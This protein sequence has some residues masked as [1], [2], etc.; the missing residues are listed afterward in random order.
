MQMA[1]QW[2]W[3]GPRSSLVFNILHRFNAPAHTLS[4][5]QSLLFYLH[6]V[7]ETKQIIPVDNNRAGNPP[8]PHPSSSTTQ[9]NNSSSSNKRSTKQVL[10]SNQQGLMSITRDSMTEDKRTEKLHDETMATVPP[11]REW[12]ISNF[13]TEHGKLQDIRYKHYQCHLS[14]LI[15]RPYGKTFD[16]NNVPL[17]FIF[18][19][20]LPESQHTFSKSNLFETCLTFGVV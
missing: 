18:L 8:R 15:S 17:F 4:P 10:T 13:I 7:I 5:L 3:S 12:L 14:L 19:S 20:F 2:A 1:G 11:P 6:N 9:H 16:H